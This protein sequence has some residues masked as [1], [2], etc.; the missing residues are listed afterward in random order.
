MFTDL[1]SLH[2]GSSDSNVL[3]YFHIMHFRSKL[4]HCLGEK[5]GV[6]TEF[7]DEKPGSV[8]LESGSLVFLPSPEMR[9]I[10]V[11]LLVFKL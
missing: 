8:S 7:G 11:I 4:C 2:T 3:F 10:W 6:Y 9:M 5:Y 1:K